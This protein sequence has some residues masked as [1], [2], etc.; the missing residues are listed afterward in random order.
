MIPQCDVIYQD[1][2]APNQVEILLKNLKFLKKGGYVLLAV[3]ARSIDV[4]KKPKDIFK[5]VER[6]LREHMSIIDK[7]RLEPFEKDHMFYV[8]RF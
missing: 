8:M 7:K 6:E 1:I 2:A 3:K 4:T 5:E